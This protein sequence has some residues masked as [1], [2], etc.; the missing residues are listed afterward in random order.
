MNSDERLVIEERGECNLAVKFTAM[1]HPCEV[2]L[3]LMPEDAALALAS[4]AAREAWRI[5]RKYGRYRVDGVTAWIHRHHAVKVVLDDETT[6]LMNFARRYFELSE[7]LFDITS[8][9]LRRAWTFDGSD[10]VPEVARVGELLPLI[11]LENVEWRAPCLL[12]PPG[13]ELDFGS[14][15]K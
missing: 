11:G 9:V 13:M 15:G 14:I 8:G 2:L 10:N 5:E 12:L 1:A 4:I 3:P 7:G 6:S